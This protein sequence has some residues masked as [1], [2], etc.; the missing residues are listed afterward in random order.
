MQ[1]KSQV[2]QEFRWATAQ[3]VTADGNNIAWYILQKAAGQGDG[4]FH[5][6]TRNVDLFN[7]MKTLH[8]VYEVGLKNMLKGSVSNIYC[9]IRNIAIDFP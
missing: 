7:L 2:E 9:R 4:S 8:N 6:M 1:A 3:C 5:Q